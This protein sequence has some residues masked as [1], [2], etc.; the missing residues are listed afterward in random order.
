MDVEEIRERIKR[1]VANVTHIKLEEIADAAS[2]KDDLALDSLSTLEI[3]VDV[4][5]QF[6]IKV[7]E[8]ELQAIETVEDT[9][10]TVQKYLKLK[11]A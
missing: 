3:V 5:Y 7:P 10:N 6:Q 11:A 8:E 2:Y 9:V 1:S 4:E